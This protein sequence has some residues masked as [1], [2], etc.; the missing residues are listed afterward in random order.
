MKKILFLTEEIWSMSK[1]SG[2]SSLNRL[3]LKINSQMCTIV[4]KPDEYDLK[5]Y[6][7]KNFKIRKN[8][9]K[10]RYLN[11]IF[12]ILIS[13]KLNL[14]YV[15]SGIKL[16]EKPDIIYV[17]SNLPCLSGFLLSKYYKVPYIQRQYGTFLYSKLNNIVE[18]IK[19][20]REVLSF[21][22][23]AQKYIITDDGTY[24]YE[25]A[26]Y[27]NIPDGKIL[28]IRNGIDKMSLD[29]S[30]EVRNN[31]ID[32]FNLPNNAFIVVSVSRLVKWKRVDRIISAFNGIDDNNVYLF[33]IGDGDE[34]NYYE[35]MKKNKNILFLG[36]ITNNEVQQF[37]KAC[38]CFVSMY[39][40][41]NLGNPLL[42][43]MAAGKPIITLNNGNTKS[44]YNGE[45]MILLPDIS[46][47]EIKKLIIKNILLLKN[48]NAY[49]KKL[50][51]AAY[52]YAEENILS[53]DERI[54][55]EISQ[56]LALCGEK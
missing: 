7:L 30:I 26:K 55:I 24:G 33:V 54:N 43:A 16:K 22:L 29:D 4:F 46:E 44:V 21:L 5:C 34:R 10:N 28:F 3:I 1:S 19:Y 27:F 47:E 52:K 6:C 23:P 32:R 12:N 39:D 2:V 15:I 20:H 17:S 41:S 48:D 36:A 40:I 25:V 53:W 49:S 42:E 51:N 35:S 8:K 18:K 11:Y 45:N 9:F 38:N 37:M 31:I 50:S 56:I 13:L 14:D